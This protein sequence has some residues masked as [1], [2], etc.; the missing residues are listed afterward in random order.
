VCTN[1]SCLHRP[2]CNGHRVDWD[3][4]RHSAQ[5]C[6]GGW[7]LVSRLVFYI[8]YLASH[9]GA[10]LNTYVL[11]FQGHLLVLKHQRPLRLSRRQ[12]EEEEEEVLVRR[13][14]RTK[15]CCELFCQIHYFFCCWLVRYIVV[16]HCEPSIEMALC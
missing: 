7:L 1:L 13:R 3:F 10:H 2:W 4:F 5:H 6:I 11:H 15:L 16:L 12:D 8:L 14:W 9:F